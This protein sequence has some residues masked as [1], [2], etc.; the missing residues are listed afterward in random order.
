[1]IFGSNIFVEIIVITKM[2][3]IVQFFFSKIVD[4]SDKH[5]GIIGIL[6][7]LTPREI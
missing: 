7:E 1:M 6:L 4:C 3:K 2:I 5:H